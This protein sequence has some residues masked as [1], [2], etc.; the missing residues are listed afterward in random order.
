MEDFGQRLAMSELHHLILAHGH[1]AA[2][3]MVP[4]NER[5]LVDAAA[6]VLAVEREELGISYSGFAL[7]SLPHKRIPDDQVWPD[8]N[9]CRRI[10][11][12]FGP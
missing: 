10:R 5:Y 11:V 4:R 1:A 9:T 12:D 2:R 3:S 8:L 7:T 6:A